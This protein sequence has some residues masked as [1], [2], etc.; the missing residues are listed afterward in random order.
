MSTTF[1]RFCKLTFTLTMLASLVLLQATQQVDCANLRGLGGENSPGWNKNHF[2]SSAMR[3]RSSETDI[4]NLNQG[5][6]REDLRRLMNKLYREDPTNFNT[7][8]LRLV[9]SASEGIRE[10][11]QVKNNDNNGEDESIDGLLTERQNRDYYGWMD[12][13]KRS[14][15]DVD[16]YQP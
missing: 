12:F 5:V 7:M 14:F 3:Q 1:R 6:S 9:R 2:E 13:G 15:D 8:I 11:S 16:D 10:I 4:S